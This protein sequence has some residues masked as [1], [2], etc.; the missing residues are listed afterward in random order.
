MPNDPTR[1]VQGEVLPPGIREVSMPAGTPFGLGFL[2][3]ARFSGIRRVLEHAALAAQAKANFHNS[4]AAVATSL[5]NREV[6]REELRNVDV[7][8]KAAADRITEGAYIGSLE[9]KLRILELEDQVAE[10]EAARRQARAP[11]QEPGQTAERTAKD[12]FDDIIADLKKI[13]ELAKTAS[14]VK[15][16][17]VRDAGGEDKL[18]EGQRVVIDTIDAIIAGVLQKQAE[19]TIL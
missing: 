18:D 17:I 12:R 9:R 14:A 8:R 1:I 7:I 3:A 16:Q 5:V 19:G 11:R 15:E 10:R 2:G 13:P 6:A 4:E